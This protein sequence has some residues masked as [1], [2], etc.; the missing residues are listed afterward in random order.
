MLE[1]R[2]APE[3][4]PNE[5]AAGVHSCWCC[6]VAAAAGEHRCWYC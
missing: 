2:G 5:E 4:G 1:G 6:E 3:K